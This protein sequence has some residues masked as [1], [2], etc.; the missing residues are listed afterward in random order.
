ML[1]N[2]YLPAQNSVLSNQLLRQEIEI[3]YSE[4]LFLEYINK[5]FGFKSQALFL[6][7]S[8]NEI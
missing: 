6:S 1:R 4:P 3:S 2:P 7:A 5:E 8:F